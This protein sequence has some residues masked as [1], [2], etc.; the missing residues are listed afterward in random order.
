MTAISEC[1]SYLEDVCIN[2]TSGLVAF[3]TTVTCHIT[4]PV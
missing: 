2:F 3:T 4:T 1:L